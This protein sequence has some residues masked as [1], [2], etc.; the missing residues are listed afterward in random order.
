[1]AELLP[2]FA[3]LVTL[4]FGFGFYLGLKEFQQIDSDDPR[5]KD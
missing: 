2:Y 4:F 5:N 1:M 3:G